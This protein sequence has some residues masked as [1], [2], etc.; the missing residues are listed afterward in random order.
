[1]AFCWHWRTGDT[2]EFYTEKTD[3]RIDLTPGSESYKKIVADIDAAAGALKTLKEH[4]IPVLWRPLHE[5]S[6]AWFWWG[7]SGPEDYI[8]LYRLMY[9][10]MTEVHH[11]D[12]LIWVW[13]GQ[14][15]DWYPGDGYVD[16]VGVDIYAPDKDNASFVDYFDQTVEYSKSKPHKLVALG[17]NGTMIDPELALKDQ[18]FWSWFMTWNDGNRG[19]PK[20][21]F[22]SGGR[23]TTLENLKKFY[24]LPCV[25]TKDRLPASWKVR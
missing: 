12:N 20:D 3:F 15:D 13:N 23:Y 4:H 21:D 10:R 18:A 6:G 24:N 7:A 9:Q 19:N 25:L 14:A 16:V 2:R 8:A 17:E 1:M 5:A 11:L 22:L